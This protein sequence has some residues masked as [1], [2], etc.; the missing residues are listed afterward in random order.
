MA[1]CRSLR[2][3]GNGD[4]EVKTNWPGRISCEPNTASAG[5]NSLTSQNEALIPSIT[6]GRCSC[7]SAAVDRDCRMSLCRLW[8][9]STS[10]LD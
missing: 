3:D 8:N 10:P 1:A 7:K 4:S 9:R 5:E 6:H 2:K